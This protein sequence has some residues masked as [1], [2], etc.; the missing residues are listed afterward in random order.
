[1]RKKIGKE[2]RRFIR[3]KAHHLLKYRV[4][5][6]EEVSKLLSFARNISAGGVLFYADKEVAPGNLVELEISFPEHPRPMKTVAR[7]VRATPMEKIGGFEMGAEFI[8]IDEA[9]RKF[10]DEKIKSVYKYTEKEGGRI[11]KVLSVIALMC[12]IVMAIGAVV[13]RFFIALPIA[14]MSWIGL[15]Q[16]CL[17]FSIA[18]G[19]LSIKK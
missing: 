16:T 2:R 4:A 6:K 10:I 1:M 17:L 18:F 7:V 5:D 9:D 19:I 13:S 12:G 11:M 14:P 15:T 3:L 8:N